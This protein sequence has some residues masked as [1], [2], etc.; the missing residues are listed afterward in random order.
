MKYR[1]N[2]GV[3]AILAVSL[4]MI[5]AGGISVAQ[6][7]AVPGQVQVASTS[8]TTT[9]NEALPDGGDSGIVKAAILKSDQDKYADDSSHQGLSGNSTLKDVAAEQLIVKITT[10]LDSYA[11][12]EKVANQ[13][14]GLI[15][16]HQQ[17]FG[18]TKMVAITQAFLANRTAGT[19]LAALGFSNDGVTTD[20]LET[21][22]QTID[23]ASS[24]T[25]LKYLLLNR[26]P[27]TDF[28]AWMDF[29]NSEKTRDKVV[30]LNADVL[31]NPDGKRITE[32]ITLAPQTLKN[33]II[34]IPFLDFNEFKGQFPPKE[35][36][37]SMTSGIQ[38]YRGEAGYLD[39]DNHLDTAYV[40]DDGDYSG[41]DKA[42][43]S[44]TIPSDLTRSWAMIQPGSPVK[45]KLEDLS[46]FN[47]LY[48]TSDLRPQFKGFFF[49]SDNYHAYKSYLETEV[50]QGFQ[51]IHSDLKQHPS[52]PNLDHVFI[53]NVPS[54]A[55]QVK[56]RTYRASPDYKTTYTQIYTIPIKSRTT[57]PTQTV[58]HHSESSSSSAESVA[59]DT[60]PVAKAK[61][62]Y[63]TKKIGLY[64]H[65]DFTN[66]TRQ[67]W[68][69]KQPRVHRP[70][71]KVTG[72]A[73]SKYGTPRY[74][75]KDVNRESKTYGKT[76]YITK[77]TTYVT[78]V[79]YAKAPA[80]VT[81][82]APKGVNAY[83]RVALTGKV[84][85]YRQG[86]VLP[87]VGITQHHL[88]TRFY[89]KDG[90]YVTANKKLVQ[91]GRLPVVKK[92]VAKTKI[93]RYPGVNLKRQSKAFHK[94]TQIVVLGYDFSAN[95]ARRYRV[96]G[97][98]VT[99]NPKLVKVIK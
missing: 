14:N 28:S 16:N 41:I 29:K 91:S 67:R 66:A 73:A 47:V 54:D 26:N 30:G 95:G 45:D 19:E 1:S 80:K 70:M 87:I 2:R 31:K 22:L 32:G 79:Y 89:L 60:Q 5:G 62:V 88:T 81:V 82:I 98:Y 4:A 68:Y 74:L 33:G 38:Y 43:W 93:N 75:V 58:P 37:D 90:T 27:I 71:F 51:F 20:D 86:Q 84:K 48:A 23:G 8:A 63:A 3:K 61:V 65:P 18:A 6:A 35:A 56:V 94:G 57:T 9:L 15:V 39:Q 85:H 92:V 46:K 53:V 36:D 11:A 50:G 42:L 55:K 24:T 12:L 52:L 13:F 83:R 69:S 34:E 96:A 7:D 76:G 64:Q 44:E 49:N 99:A 21:L 97:G 10:R 17:N 78:P 40:L 59:T 25:T 72:E 77:R